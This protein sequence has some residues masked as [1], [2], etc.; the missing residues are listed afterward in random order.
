MPISSNINRRSA[1][2][3]GLKCVNLNARSIV[4][5]MDELRRMADDTQPDIIGITETWTKPD[6]GDAEFGLAGYKMFRKDRLVKRGGGVMLYFKEHIQAYE[7]QI[8]A[9]AGFS[10]AIWCNLES[11]GSKIIVGVV[12][13]CPSISKDEDTS[14]H[15]VI[16]H[17]S[18]GECLIMGDFNHP[19]IRWNSLDSSKESAKFL[20]LVQN[21]FLTQHVLEPTRGDNVLDLILSSNKELVDNVTVVEPLGTSDHS[22]IHF[23]LTVKTGSRYSKQRKRDFK[24]GDYVQ[25]RSYLENMKWAEILENKT[26]EQCWKSLKSEF[27]YIIQKFIPNK[28]CSHLRKKHLSREAMQMIRN[29]QRLWK[30]YKRTGNV[31]DYAKYKDA[32]KETTNEIRESKR[33]FERKLAAN[34]KQDSKSFF[35]YIRSKQKVRDVVGPLKD[36]DGLVITKGKE[37]A[38]A[39]NIYFSSVFTLEDKNNLPVHEPLLA[40]NVECLTN[41]LITPAMIVTKIKKLKD[42]KSPGIDGI[43]P[44]L[45]KEIAEEI[46]VP[47]AI[48]FNLSLREGTVPPEW[49]H[50]NVVPIFKKGSRCKAEN[51]RPVSLTSVVCKLLESLLRDHMIDFLEKHNLLKDTQH[52]FLK[53]RS[54]L[55]NLLE[56]TEIISKWVDDGSPVDVIYLDFQK[57]F[58][59]VPHQRLLIKLKS[60]GINIV[61]WIQNWLTDRKQRVSVDGETSAWTAVHSGVPQGSVL[62]PLLFLIYI[63]DLEDGVASNILKFADDTKIFRRVQTRQEC[64]TLQDDLNRLDQ[65]SAKWQM[66]FNQSKCKCLHIGRANGKEP[67]EMHNTVLLKTSKEKDLGV[68]ISADWKVSEQCGI[69]ARK[70]N[71]LLGMIKRN[72]TYREKNL[73]IPLYKSIVRPHLEYCIQA[74]RPHLKKDID[75]LE[76]V[77]RRATKLIPE[78]RILSY[79]DRVQQCK[80]TTLETRRVRGDQIEVFKIT[81]GIEGLD[82]DMFFKFRTDNGT[83][84]HSWALAKEWCKLDIR[85]YAFSQRTINEWNR[86]PGECVHATSVNMFKNKIDNYFK[87]SG[88]V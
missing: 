15:K 46:S 29:K 27:D 79:E 48:M 41:M 71:Q 82:S 63:N 78:L 64:R 5:K 75:K 73:I 44:K 10:E 84:G 16:T 53:G 33:N 13:R 26:A 23:N 3:S 30:A 19:D 58:D 72:I 45:L 76:R 9:E 56:Y 60:H 80:L 7:I 65:W 54:C 1:S 28:K 8:E 59:K 22:Q 85:K 40:D 12:Y 50:A 6:M 43:T 34:I 47:L 66:L 49:K 21:C 37:M 25:M 31:E 88:Y 87:R 69:A 36:N 68:T 42:N 11:Q 61:A 62:G 17:A 4:S 39:L 24:K 51:Y 86:L 20:L 35:A 70:G 38:D 52:G 18:R 81:H 57:A 67:Y 83:R 55:T 2:H 14:L 74:W 77:Q 32:L